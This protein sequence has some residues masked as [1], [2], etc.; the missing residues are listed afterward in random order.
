MENQVPENLLSNSVEANK[1]VTAKTA[2]DI[3]D[4]FKELDVEDVKPEKEVKE[5]KI[6]EDEEVDEPKVKKDK[7]S[8]G[9]ADDEDE[10]LELVEDDEDLEKL[11]LKADDEDIG[12]I[13]GP[14]RKKEIVKEFPEIFKKFPF[15]EKMLYRDKQYSELFGSFDDA[16]EIAEKSEVFN[17]FETQLLSGNTEEILRNVKGTDEK[18]FNL[19][20]DDYLPT[21]AKVDKEAYFHVTGNLNKRL[22]MEMVKEANETDND[23]LKQAALLVNQFIFGTSK[24]E[25][26]TRRVEK[27]EEVD[28]V[29]NEVEKERLEFTKER[30]ETSRDE[31]Q[32]RVDNKLRNTISEYIDPKGAMSSYVKKNAVKD[33][34]NY[35]NESI[36][37]SSEI[38]KNLDKLWRSSFDSKFS[39]DSLGKVESYYLSKAK[40]NLKQAIMK[41]RAEALKDSQPRTN[42]REVEEEKEE[43]PPQRTRI[44][45]GR[46]SQERKGKNDRQRGESVADFFMRD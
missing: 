13:D 18:A 25:A 19:I 26:P 31:M 22:I 35:L 9:E 10:E 14:P 34:M 11:D 15:L 16:K 24:F 43:T 12:E 39:R 37:S 42:K 23:D 7:S 17:Q 6:K 45:T 5:P 32:T 38:K 33:A 1:P 2:D 3:N 30:Y 8:D 40:A 27:N 44:A 41:A 28:K 20:V 46:P 36:N 21:L 4:L 29:K